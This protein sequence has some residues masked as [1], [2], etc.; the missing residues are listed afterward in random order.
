M[1]LCELQMRRRK[2]GFSLIYNGRQARPL[3]PPSKL[4]KI[5]DLKFG[6]GIP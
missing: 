3:R 5:N 6:W 2:E 1:G 4:S